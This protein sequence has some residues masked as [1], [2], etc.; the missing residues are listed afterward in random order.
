MK[1]GGGGVWCLAEPKQ[2]KTKE[3]QSSKDI[4]GGKEENPKRDKSGEVIFLAT[5]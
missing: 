4:G 2:N 1:W 5:K 3:K